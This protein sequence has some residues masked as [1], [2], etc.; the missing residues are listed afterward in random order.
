MDRALLT[1]VIVVAGAGCAG[2]ENHPTLATRTSLEGGVVNVTGD[3]DLPDGAQLEVGA[4]PGCL[5]ADASPDTVD[6]VQAT[7]ANGAFDASLTPDLQ[8][9]ADDVTVSVTFVPGD[10]AT[11]DRYGQFGEKMSGEG[12][13]E[14][15]GLHLYRVTVCHRR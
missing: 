2:S 6:H 3:T 12:V 11:A 10:A 15:I 7:V 1:L 8:P 4:W 5:G 13:F 14:D 9:H